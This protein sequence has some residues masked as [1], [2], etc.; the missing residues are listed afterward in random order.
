VRLFAFYLTALD[1]G[2]RPGELFALVWSDI[3]LEGRFLTITKS[4][5]EI[6]GAL[7]VKEAKTSKSRRRIERSGSGGRGGHGGGGRRY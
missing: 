7:R 3:D 2:A 1:S 4:L 6:S 5:E